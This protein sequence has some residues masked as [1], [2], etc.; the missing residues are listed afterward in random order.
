MDINKIIDI[1]RTLKEEGAIANAVGAPP[2]QGQPAKIAGIHGDPPVR[3]N[4][5][6]RDKSMLTGDQVHVRTGWYNVFR[7]KSCSVRNEVGYL[8]R[9]F[10]RDAGKVGNCC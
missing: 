10:Q 2:A 1:V 6:K 3:K 5:N 8:R 9:T 7:F 4:K